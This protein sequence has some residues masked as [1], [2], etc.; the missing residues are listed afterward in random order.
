MSIKLATLLFLGLLSA[1]LMMS[2]MLIFVSGSSLVTNIV[3]LN[4]P[5]TAIYA[6][7]RLVRIMLDFA[8]IWFFLPGVTLI[9]LSFLQKK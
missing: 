8:N 5:L 7:S 4:N 2:A 6:Q 1:G 3:M 9:G